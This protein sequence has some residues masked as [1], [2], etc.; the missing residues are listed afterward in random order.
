LDLVEA[1]G[2]CVKG[3]I[4]KV[5]D[6]FHAVGC[7]PSVKAQDSVELHGRVYAVTGQGRKDFHGSDTGAGVHVQVI[8]HVLQEGW[9]SLRCLC[10]DIPTAVDGSLKARQVQG[11]L[12]A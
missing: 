8:H 1:L 3:L 6:H 7:R 11:L 12:A 9:G 10:R 4:S 5:V 2:D